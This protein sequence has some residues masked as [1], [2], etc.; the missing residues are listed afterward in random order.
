MQN[1]SEICKRYG[2]CKNI[3]M[4]KYNT[5]LNRA[6]A[7]K[8]KIINKYNRQS[9]Y[10][11]TPS[12]MHLNGGIGYNEANYLQSL[13]NEAMKRELNNVRYPMK[14]TAEF[15]YS[16][17]KSKFWRSGRPHQQTNLSKL[18]QA[19][20]KE[21]QEKYGTV[22]SGHVKYPGGKIGLFNKQVTAALQ[23]RK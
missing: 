5:A 16:K 20:L 14:P 17:N 15:V 1:Q 3:A 23:A 9:I 12:S 11:Y 19:K 2:I 8:R 22:V 10:N 18:S 21:K 4:Q 13:K 6:N 7:E